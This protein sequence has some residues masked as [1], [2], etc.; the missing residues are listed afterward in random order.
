MIRCTG[1]PTD[2]VDQELNETIQKY[3]TV[4]KSAQIF[5]PSLPSNYGPEISSAY[6]DQFLDKKMAE[7]PDLV[8]GAMLHQN[9]DDFHAL[10]DLTKLL[11]C[12][13]DNVETAAE[14]EQEGD[15]ADVETSQKDDEAMRSVSINIRPAFGCHA[16]FFGYWSR[17]VSSTFKAIAENQTFDNFILVVII[18]SSISLALENPYVSDGMLLALKIGDY[19]WM[20]IFTIEFMIKIVA[21]GPKGYI[22]DGW[23]RL[24][25]L[26][27]FFT[28]FS[29]FGGQG[30]AGGIGRIFRI[31]RTLRPLRM[32]NKNPE[33]KLIINS[34][35]GSLPAVSNALILTLFVFFVFAVFGLNSFMGQ[36]W[37]CN[38][39]ELDRDECEGSAVFG[40]GDAED[41]YL[42]PRVWINN[43][44]NF[45]D[46]VMSLLTLYNSATTE[47]WVDLMYACMDINGEVCPV[48][49][50]ASPQ[51]CHRAKHPS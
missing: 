33:M 21:W 2:E 44:Q 40:T 4:P 24:D 11:G 13:E 18:L 29:M 32:I 22:D 16:A 5:V 48:L 3:M 10:T 46:I 47:G 9:E 28:Y 6:L 45:D 34:V 19:C 37:Y 43:R 31:G 39:G 50:L 14:D 23:N 12:D 25:I 51:R 42:K 27:L 17:Q 1:K 20:I 7:A 49:L 35:I 41:E 26:V 38:D 15:A 36:L 8:S 30:L